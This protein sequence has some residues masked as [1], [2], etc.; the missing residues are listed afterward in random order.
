MAAMISIFC[1]SHVPALMNL[2]LENF[3]HENNVLLLIFMI[4]VVQSSDVLQYVW[5]KAVGK[6]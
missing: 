5:G 3:P 4:V 6:R 1:V 2:H